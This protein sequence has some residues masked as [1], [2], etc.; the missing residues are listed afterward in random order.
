MHSRPL[1]ETL[2]H[3][4]CGL[5]ELWP[6][7]RGRAEIRMLFVFEPDRAAFLLVVS[8]KRG[9]S[10]GMSARS[11]FTE[12]WAAKHPAMAVSIGGRFRA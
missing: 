10:V 2:E 8:G 7:S 3:S 9:W 5:N 4:N 6:G 11:H 1:V 12:A